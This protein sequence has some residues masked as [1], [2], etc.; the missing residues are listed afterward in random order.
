[1]AVLPSAER[2]TEMPWLATP[3]VPVPTS[4]DPC[5]VQT[6]PLLVQNPRGPRTSIVSHTLPTTAAIRRHRRGTR[7]RPARRT[8]RRRCRPAWTP[9]WVQT[10]PLRVQTHAAPAP[11]L[12]WSPFRTIA[13]LPSAERDNGITLIGSSPPRPPEP[14]SLGPPGPDPSAPGQDPGRPRTTV[15]THDPPTIAVLPSADRDTEVPCLALQRRR[16][17]TSLSPCWPHTPLLLVN[18][19]PPRQ[20]PRY[21]QTHPRWRCCRRRTGDTPSPCR[22]SPRRRCR[23]AWSLAGVHTTPLRVHT[24][25][26]PAASLSARP[27]DDGG[28]AV[29]RQERRSNPG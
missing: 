8:P 14:T 27:A 19:P 28:V 20:H 16:V 22:R 29:G 17:P 25:A 11:P 3:T 5:W 7:Q 6:P 18:G 23:P 24:H 4:L 12:S 15:V 2:D 1:M 21:R 10:P 9:C 13:V 26:T